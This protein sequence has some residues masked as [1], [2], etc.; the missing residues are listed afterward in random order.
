MDIDLN[1]IKNN[2]T[3][4]QKAEE[5]I[6]KFREAPIKGSLAWYVSFELSKRYALIAVEEMLGEYQSMSDLES[7]IVIND[8]V[9]FVVHQLVYW[10]E[11]KQEIENL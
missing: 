8:E 4:K 9:K 6:L 5:L 3:P 10:M 1:F 7:I 11:V 2:M